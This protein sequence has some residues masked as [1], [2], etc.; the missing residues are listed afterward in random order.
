VD[1]L[2]GRDTLP[3]FDDPPSPD[4]R[5]T[6]PPPL[7][8]LPLD[9]LGREVAEPLL[10]PEVFGRCP[11]SLSCASTGRANAMAAAV[12][13]DVNARGVITAPILT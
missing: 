2:P 7:L 11:C 9:P 13:I 1:P 10:L 8:E 12:K 5:D 4:G 3:V 6:A